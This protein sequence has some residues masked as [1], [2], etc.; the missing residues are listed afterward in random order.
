[1]ADKTANR[2]ER[3]RKGI[4]KQRETFDHRV[5]LKVMF[6]G[7]EKGLDYPTTKPLY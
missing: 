3:E 2:N 7:K 6:V 4:Q 5:G 1:M